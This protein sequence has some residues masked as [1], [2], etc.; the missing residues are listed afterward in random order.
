MTMSA[1]PDGEI[2][3]LRSPVIPAEGFIHGFP[4]RAGGISTGL[5]SVQKRPRSNAHLFLHLHSARMVV[6]WPPEGMIPG[7]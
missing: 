5:I 6:P 4:T 2:E 3:V 7:S 1:T